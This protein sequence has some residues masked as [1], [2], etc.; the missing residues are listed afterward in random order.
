MKKSIL[1][2]LVLIQSLSYA[3]VGIGTDDAPHESAILELKSNSAGFLMPR[4]TCTERAAITPIEG[5]M[6][7]TTDINGWSYYNGAKWIN[8]K[9]GIEI[10]PTDDSFIQYGSRANTAM[11]DVRSDRMETRQDDFSIGGGNLGYNQNH[12]EGYI[13]FDVSK[14]SCINQVAK[15]EV[16]LVIV[17]YSNANIGLAEVQVISTA[18][19][20]DEA[21]LT[22]NNKPAK[23]GDVTVI[24]DDSFTAIGK[25]IVI[26]VTAQV[27]AALD[28]G[29][30]SISLGLISNTIVNGPDDYRLINFATKENSEP[31][32]PFI[33]L[34]L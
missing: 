31:N 20:W 7:F 23:T 21:T 12:R 6:V 8:H 25:K 30:V 15:A 14:N 5:L 33:T 9:G 1:I 13:K 16:T 27:N 17:G 2:L 24:A 4:L 29:E 10:P 3:Q 34:T 22:A 32:R 19:N 11:Q 18:T 26:D 28:A